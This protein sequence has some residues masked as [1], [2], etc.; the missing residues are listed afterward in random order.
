MDA[1]RLDLFVFYLNKIL[2]VCP[3][4][5]VILLNIIHPYNSKYLDVTDDSPSF[6]VCFWPVVAR[7]VEW[8]DIFFLSQVRCDKYV[9]K[10]DS[11]TNHWWLH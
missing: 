3:C 1:E 5:Q 8:Q 7:R 10:V 4:G 11:N 6:G 2:F 9:M